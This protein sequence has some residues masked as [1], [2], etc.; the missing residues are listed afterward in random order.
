M[1]REESTSWTNYNKVIVLLLP[2]LN[3]WGK[4]MTQSPEFISRKGLSDGIY[5]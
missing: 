5:M 3:V 1:D 4:Q 2:L